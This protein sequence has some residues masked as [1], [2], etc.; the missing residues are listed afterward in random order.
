VTMKRSRLFLMVLFLMLVVTACVP[1]PRNQADADAK[2]RASEQAAAD[3]EQAR[4]QKQAE[5]AREQAKWDA[6][7][8]QWTATMNFLIRWVGITMAITLCYVIARMGRGVGIAVEGASE[9][10]KIYAIQRAELTA[11]LIY[12]DKE[13]RTYPLLRQAMPFGLLAEGSK[14]GEEKSGEAH[15]V[16]LGQ[17]RYVLANPDGSVQPLDLAHEADRQ[18]IAA[19]GAVQ[20]A[21]VVAREARRTRDGESAAGVAAIQPVV[22]GANDKTQGLAVGQFV[23]MM[24]EMTGAGSEER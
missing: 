12:L 2:T 22:V 3:A 11:N 15:L 5:A 8:A 1:D 23:Q 18:K 4:A 14:P 13:T 6:I 7:Q 17:R 19:A 20:L 21:G 10:F 9:A 24:R 16:A